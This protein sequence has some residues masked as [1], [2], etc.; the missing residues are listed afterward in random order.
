MQLFKVDNKSGANKHVVIKTRLLLRQAS[1]L[2]L[3][4]RVSG[5]ADTGHVLAVGSTALLGFVVNRVNVNFRA[6]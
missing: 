5:V 6:R 4:E 2:E 1:L 3:V